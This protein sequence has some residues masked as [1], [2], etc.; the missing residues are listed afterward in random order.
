MAYRAAIPSLLRE[1][2]WSVESLEFNEIEDPDPENHDAR[3]RQLIR[4]LDEARKEAEAKPE[5]RR[6]GIFKRGKLAERKGW[7]TYDESMKATPE[8]SN[9]NETEKV[10]NAALFDIDA[11]RAELASEHM[12]VR[13]LESTLPPMKLTLNGASTMPEKPHEPSPPLRETK[14]FDEAQLDSRPKEPEINRSTNGHVSGN[15]SFVNSREDLNEHLSNV[16][17][18]IEMSFEPTP[19][20]LAGFSRH[21][22]TQPAPSSPTRPQ[23]NHAVTIP[24]NLNNISLEHNAWV[25]E[26]EEMFGH[27]REMKL[28]F[29]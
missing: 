13:Q 17:E 5:K 20:P 19:H 4:E 26:D 11:I 9:A 23:L 29:E 10:E 8:S 12:E 1:L 16:E 22:D 27:E 15:R 18:K 14:S 3:Q 6:F 28:S 24:S 21:L 2:G 7:E 25:D